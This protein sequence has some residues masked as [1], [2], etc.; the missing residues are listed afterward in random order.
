MKK[1]ELHLKFPIDFPIKN[2]IEASIFKIE[3]DL[4]R[5]SLSSNLQD[6]F[7]VVLNP[8][9]FEFFLA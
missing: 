2:C 7:E 9:D 4:N 6:I 1:H 5:E 8:D 3:I